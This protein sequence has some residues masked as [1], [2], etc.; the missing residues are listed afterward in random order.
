MKLEIFIEYS[1]LC[2]RCGNR[3]ETALSTAKRIFR[4]RG[5]VM[6]KKETVC[7]ECVKKSFTNPS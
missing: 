2:D 7:P 4:K 5:W 6:I 3:D 1:I